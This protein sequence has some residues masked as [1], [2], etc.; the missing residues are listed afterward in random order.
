MKPLTTIS[1]F[2][3]TAFLFALSCSALELGQ[4]PP[5]VELKGK[6]GGRLDGKLWS[7][8]E[9]KSRNFPPRI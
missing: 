4:A 7:S 9:L 5:R 3:L 8:C 6:L 1:V 2:I